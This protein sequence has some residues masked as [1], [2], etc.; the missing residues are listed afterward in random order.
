[1]ENKVDITVALSVYNVKAF[2]RQALEC[3]LNQSYRDIEIL[4]IDDASDDGT[5][6]ILNQYSEKDYRIRLIR[7]E[8]NSG[9]SVS[10][11]RAIAEARGDYLLML[12]GD[13]LFAPDLI[14]KVVSKATATD[15]DVVLWDYVVFYNDN[16]IKNKREVESSLISILPTD[17]IS[18]LRQPSFMWTKLYKTSWLRDN[19]ICFPKGLTKQDIPVWWKT[20]T[21]TERIAL[22]PERL[23]FYRQQPDSTSNKKGKSVFSLAYVMDIVGKQLKENNLYKVYR[24]EYLRSRLSLLQGMYDCILPELKT[25]ALAMVKERLGED[26]QAYISNPQN[27]LSSRVRD[28]YGMLNGNRM[29]SIRYKGLL[30]ARFVY[31]LFKKPM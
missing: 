24:D 17:K 31:R 28:F 25:E 19:D 3:I 10:R 1:M 21:S 14:E 5:W 7:Q 18:L 11:N 30:S 8:R 9:L 23:S 12:D 29:A 20:V 13:D 6:E 22:F 26:E 15:A 4:C 27:E 2:I 16:E